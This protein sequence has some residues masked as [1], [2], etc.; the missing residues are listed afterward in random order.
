[1]ELTLKQALQKGV[2]AHREGKLKDAERLYRAILK[3]HPTHP[4]ANHN[5]GVLAVS[6]NKTNLAIPFFESA[7]KANSNIEQYWLSYIEA[8]IKQERFENATQVLEQSRKRSF[9]EEKLNRLSAMLPQS[10]LL[11]KDKS[12]SKS[13]LIESPKNVEE[14]E[15]GKIG[16]SKNLLSSRNPPQH[17]LSRLDKLYKDGEY[18]D[19]EE[20]AL[21]ITREFPKHSVAWKLLGAILAVTGRNSEAINVFKTAVALSPRDATVH[22]NLGS[23]LDVTGSLD[24]AIISF[25]HAITLASDFPEAHKRLGKTLLKLGRH[26]EGLRERR[27]G[28]GVMIFDLEQGLKVT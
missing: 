3:S 22:F 20:L 7:L 9:D 17:I 6:V 8:L 12:D 25:R 28:E 27:L 4:D 5:L 18:G 1:M 2:A 14:F 19:A 11:K 23:M 13:E 15:E 16:L 24:D 10:R 26:Q 21:S